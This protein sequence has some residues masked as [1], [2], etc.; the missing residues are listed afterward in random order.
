M[1]LLLTDEEMAVL[2]SVTSEQ[3]WNDACEQIKKARNG[4]YPRDWFARVLKSGLINRV[5]ARFGQE[6]G[7]KLTSFSS[8]GVQGP[9]TF[10]PIDYE[11][12]S[13]G[14]VTDPVDL[15]A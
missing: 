15:S 8:S 14:S 1:D 5:T 10:H 7:F 9:T 2:E 4:Q 3:Q 11:K 6:P 12:E 13:T